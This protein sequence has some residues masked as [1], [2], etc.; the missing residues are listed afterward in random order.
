CA[1]P[2]CH[3]QLRGRSR[4]CNQRRHRAPHPRLH[5][6][7]L[8]PNFSTQRRG[9]RREKQ[10]KRK[11]RRTWMIEVCN[12]MQLQFSAL[13]CNSASLRQLVFCIVKVDCC[14]FFVAT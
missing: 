4:E 7:S 14:E 13:L 11:N 8:T 12:W 1:A 9:G 6:R 5:R 10:R 2:P 3:H